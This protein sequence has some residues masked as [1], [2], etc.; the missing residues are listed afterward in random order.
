MNEVNEQI[1][2]IEYNDV[3]GGIKLSSNPFTLNVNESPYL[4]NVDLSSN[5]IFARG[6]YAF[7]EALPEWINIVEIFDYYY[8][9]EY[10][11]IAVAYPYILKINPRNYSWKI[12]YSKWFSTGKPEAAQ[13]PETIMIVDGAN[14]PLQITD[15]TVTELTWPQTLTNA[16]NAAGTSGDIGNIVQSIFNTRTDQQPADFGVPNHVLY[17]N[18][19]FQVTEINYRNVV[20]FSRWDDFTDF[21]TNAPADYDVA[22]FIE[23]PTPYDVTGWELLNNEYVVIYLTNGYIVQSG[24]Q[25][26]GIGYPEPWLSWQVRDTI[27]GCLNSKLIEKNSEG[28]H[29]YITS[30]NR[31]F[32]LKSSE[33]FNQAKTEGLSEDIYPLLESFSKEQWEKSIMINNHVTGELLIFA[34]SEEHDGYPTTC[35]VYKYSSQ[36]RGWTLE[37]AWGENFILTAAHLDLETGQVVLVNQGNRLLIHD[38]GT[39]FDGYPVTTIAE[40]RP[41]DFGNTSKMKEVLGAYFVVSNVSDGQ[42]I[43]RWRWDNNEESLEIVTTTKATSIEDL[44]DLTEVENNILSDL[45]DNFKVIGVPMLNKTGQILKQRIETN[46]EQKLEINKMLLVYKLHG[47]APFSRN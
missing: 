5:G 9:G 27:N 4:I 41:E 2:T 18:N 6:G 14:K 13:S 1:G 21:S 32:S 46:K 44:K 11:W 39:N 29:F 22:F 33:N 40:I 15:E 3:S 37:S 12:L 10:N 8:N 24:Q 38:S 23:L 47:I 30:K 35:Y 28:D 34:P 45:G 42:F 16:N 26:P 31:L 25:P 36:T 20:I 43:Y 17:V 19:R 7:Q